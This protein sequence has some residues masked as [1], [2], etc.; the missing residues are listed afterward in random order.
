MAVTIYLRG[1]P[2]IQEKIQLLMGS[3]RNMEPHLAWA[4]PQFEG[5]IKRNFA[6]GGRPTGWVAKADGSPARLV[7]SNRL[8]GGIKGEAS[9]DEIRIGTSGI[10]YAAI[11]HFGGMTGRKHAARMPARPYMVIIPEEKERGMKKILESMRRE[12]KI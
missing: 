5:A 3:V 1:L 12:L 10:P 11:H 4:V 7:K 6:A 9:G 8:R 2:E